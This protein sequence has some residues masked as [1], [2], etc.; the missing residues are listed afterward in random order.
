[1][2]RT[3]L[4][5]IIRAVAAI[6]NENELIVIGSQAILGQYPNA[7]DKLLV[8]KEADIY[9]PARPDLSDLIDGALGELSQ[10]ETTFGY[11]A[12]GVGPGT[13]TLPR[14]WKDRLIPIV[15]EN[16]N[17]ATGWCLECHDIAVAKYVAGREKDLRYIADLWD[18]DLI[19]PKI[20]EQRLKQTPM[21]DEVRRRVETRMRQDRAR[22][23]RGGV[24]A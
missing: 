16:T 7:P 8:S 5:H 9:V 4:E 15:N 3:E 12:D 24:R 1:M 18:E 2:T 6:T 14:G 20:M 11:R 17:G 13:A 19:D 21:S 10:F 22:Y 23:G